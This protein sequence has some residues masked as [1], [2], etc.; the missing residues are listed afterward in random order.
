MT[1]SLDDIDY[2]SLSAAERLLLAQNLLDSVYDHLDRPLTLARPAATALSEPQR[3][4]V[5]E[6]V[7]LADADPTGGIPWEDVQRE[8]ADRRQQRR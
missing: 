8:L 1:I 4:R 3:Q 6:R 7:A 5:R 2:D